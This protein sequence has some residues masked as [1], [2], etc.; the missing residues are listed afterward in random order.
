MKHN[1]TFILEKRKGLD[2]SPITEKV[3]LFA[4]IR[5]AG[6]R[7]Y[8]FTGFRIDVRNF[9]AEK[10]EAKRNSTGYEGKLKVQYNVINK[11]MTLIRAAMIELFDITSIAPD[12]KSIVARLDET[13]L[14]KKRVDISEAPE[15]ISFFGLFEKYIRDTK[16]SEGRKRHHKSTLNHWKNFEKKQGFTITFENM[17]TD[18]LV[19]FEKFLLADKESP[20][21]MNTLHAIFASTRAFWN[22]AIRE[23]ESK[24]IILHNPFKNYSIPAE[25]YGVP[26]YISKEERDML[27]NAEIKVEKLARVRDIFIFQC[28]TGPRVGDLCKLTKAN[29]IDGILSYIPRKTKDDKPV[30]VTV[31]LGKKAI[32]IL[33]RYNIPDGRILP[34]ISAVKYNKYLKE[35]FEVVGLTRAVTRLNPISRQEEQVRLCDIASSHM[36][37]RTFAGNLY[38]LVKDDVIGSMTGHV[39][40]SKSF[41]RYHSVAPELQKQAITMID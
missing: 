16:L 12:K 20:R 10:Q 13:C 19:A 24:G 28:L 21:G 26:I 1:I 7:I 41:S 38:S 14:K 40:G 37:R 6:S 23:F 11:R 15:E 29:I 3:P 33:S 17:N 36:G 4:D 18:T 34:F 5:F 22:Y 35:L 2:G 25:V 31:P 39:P 9:D 8:Y 27:F 30:A 32:E